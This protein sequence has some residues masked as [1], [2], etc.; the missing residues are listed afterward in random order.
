M[1]FGNQTGASEGGIELSVACCQMRPADIGD[2]GSVGMLVG[3]E[4]KA[5]EYCSIAKSLSVGSERIIAA[6]R[7]FQVGIEAVGH[8]LNPSSEGG[9]V[10]HVDHGPVNIREQYSGTASPNG[11]R[12]EDFALLD[13]VQHKVRS[14]ADLMLF[15]HRLRRHYDDVAEQLLS[16]VP[17]L[18]GRPASDIGRGEKGGDKYP[19]VFEHMLAVERIHRHGDI[20]PSTNAPQP[21][22][23]CPSGQELGGFKP[24]NGK[25]CCDIG[26]L[27][28]IAGSLHY[29]CEPSPADRQHIFGRRSIF[30]IHKFTFLENFVKYN[31][32]MLV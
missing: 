28:D 5:L 15:A 17:V 29:G 7:A 10:Q 2:T 19:R 13:V 12:T 24:A 26:N 23:A 32:L 31:I 8:V 27:D 11:P 3:Q 1:P 30:H 22:L 6:I 4:A 9:I 14:V 16:K 25:C 21:A 20:G 18:S